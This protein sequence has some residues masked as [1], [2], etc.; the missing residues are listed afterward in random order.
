MRKTLLMWIEHSPSFRIATWTN[1]DCQPRCHVFLT[2]SCGDH[3]NIFC[4]YVHMNSSHNPYN[5][6][7]IIIY[8]SIFHHFQQG[9]LAII[10]WTCLVLMIDGSGRSSSWNMVNKSHHF[11]VCN[12]QQGI[13]NNYQMKMENVIEFFYFIDASP[14]K[15][16]S[17]I[18]FVKKCLLSKNGK[19]MD[20]I[21]YTYGSYYLLPKFIVI[22]YGQ[23]IYWSTIF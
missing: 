17:Y 23:W 3:Y 4:T 14:N 12:S 8:F 11:F 13:G 6:H 21:N 9:Y 18:Y 5:L 1:H 22:L 10:L 16:F 20:Y 19:L 15:G 7:T 2:V